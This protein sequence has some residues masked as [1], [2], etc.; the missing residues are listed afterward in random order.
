MFISGTN[1]SMKNLGKVIWGTKNHSFMALQWKPW[2]FPSPLIIEWSFHASPSLQTHTLTLVFSCYQVCQWWQ[3]VGVIGF[4]A[5]RLS[6]HAPER[7]RHVILVQ[8]K[9]DV[10]FSLHIDS[11]YSDTHLIKDWSFKGIF[12]FKHLWHAIN[13]HS[14][15]FTS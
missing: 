2:M 1:G 10:T 4:A 8:V 12:R 14:K 3:F 6:S 7:Q 5:T 11:V 9:Y 13:E 15:C